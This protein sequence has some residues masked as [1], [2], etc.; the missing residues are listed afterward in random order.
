[1]ASYA[2]LDVPRERFGVEMQKAVRTIAGLLIPYPES[3]RVEG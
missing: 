1:M 2:V 3:G